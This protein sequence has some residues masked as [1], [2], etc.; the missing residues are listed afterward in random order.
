MSVTDTRSRLSRVYSLRKASIVA[1]PFELQTDDS[2][3][4]PSVPQLISKPACTSRPA[5]KQPSSWSPRRHPKTAKGPWLRRTPGIDRRHG[6]C[7]LRSSLTCPGQISQQFSITPFSR[8]PDESE[9]VAR[10]PV[11]KTRLGWQLKPISDTSI[12][13]MMT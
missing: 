5:C 3:P 13:S 6:S 8:G 4:L 1:P 9:G 2:N 12:P 10:L 7:C 11:R